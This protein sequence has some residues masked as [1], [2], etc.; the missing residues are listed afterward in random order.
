[1]A[2]TTHRREAIGEIA[3]R[4]VENARRAQ[5]SEIARRAARA[6]WSGEPFA[7]QDEILAWIRSYVVRHGCSPGVRDIRD[8]F[9]YRSATAVIV[10]LKALR[11]RGLLEPASRSVRAIRP[12]TP[13]G[14]CA[15]C[16][17]ALPAK[18]SAGG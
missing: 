4:R 14:C 9:G 18:E 1:M 15:A 10:H 17:Q 6:R 13:P 16:L 7:R 12:V 8:G 3:A 5:R 11:K 2:A